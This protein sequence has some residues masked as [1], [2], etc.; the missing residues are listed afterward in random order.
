MIYSTKDSTVNTV[1]G[2]QSRDA[3]NGHSRNV[4]YYRI[5]TVHGSQGYSDTLRK[6]HFR[7]SRGRLHFIV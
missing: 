2:R 4:L 6:G 5:Q 1:K 3:S 7:E